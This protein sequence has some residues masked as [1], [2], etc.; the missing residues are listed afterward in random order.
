[1]ALTNES[2]NIATVDED[3]AS[4]NFEFDQSSLD[5]QPQKKAKYDP[6]SWFQIDD[7][8]MPTT[9]QITNIDLQLKREL[10]MYLQETVP[11]RENFNL[12][13]WW[14]KN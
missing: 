3:V 7:T 13:D 4:T 14:K 8:T 2:V 11:K 12:L 10:Q 5:I 1:M 9:N 6:F